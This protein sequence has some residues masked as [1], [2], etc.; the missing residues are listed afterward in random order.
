MYVIKHEGLKNEIFLINGEGR[1]IL[2]YVVR[3]D[4]REEWPECMQ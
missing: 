3:D 1:K 4:N 2:P